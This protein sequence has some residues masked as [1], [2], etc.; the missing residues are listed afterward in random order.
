MSCSFKV[1][2]ERQ[3]GQMIS[4]V[5]QEC[6]NMSPHLAKALFTLMVSYESI[7][8]QL[9]VRRDEGNLKAPH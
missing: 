5:G 3:K 8:I 2:S 4:H 9:M 1:T 6:E 7:T